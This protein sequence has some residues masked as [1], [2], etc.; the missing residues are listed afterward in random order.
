MNFEVKKKV[1]LHDTD[2]TDIVYYSRHLEWFEE[3]RIDFISSIYKSLT[4]LIEEDK[5]SFLPINVNIDYKAPAIFE[6]ILTIKL[7]VKE[8]QKLKLV[9]DYQIIKEIESKE[10]LVSKT[11]ITMLCIDIEKNGRPRKI[12]ENLVQIFTEYLD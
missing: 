7:K 1:Y 8:I 10:I 5:I 6:D 2:A 3:V 11:E 4:K 12:P 9:L